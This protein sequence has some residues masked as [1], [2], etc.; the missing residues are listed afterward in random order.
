MPWNWRSQAATSNQNRTIQTRISFVSSSNQ[1]DSLRFKINF[2]SRHLN[3]TS[4]QFQ[5]NFDSIP[6]ISMKIDHLRPGRVTPT[7]SRKLQFFKRISTH[8][9]NDF[10]PAARS[11]FFNIFRWPKKQTFLITKTI[12]FDRFLVEIRKS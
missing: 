4:I 10:S 11:R 7:A 6:F 1:F 5:F 12:D 9:I 3:S 2:N 8:K